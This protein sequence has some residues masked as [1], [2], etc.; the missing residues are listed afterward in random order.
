MAGQ[1]SLVATRDV[2]PVVVP[3]QRVAESEWQAVPVARLELS[4]GRLD[5]LPVV[6]NLWV[7]A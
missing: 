1:G 5:E 6:Q 4:F 7:S 3:E 2:A